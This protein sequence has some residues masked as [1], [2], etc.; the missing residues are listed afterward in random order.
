MLTAIFVMTI[1]I[2]F[3]QLAGSIVGG[4]AA[5]RSDQRMKRDQAEHERRMSATE[6]VFSQT[7]AGLA[8]SPPP[9]APLHVVP[10]PKSKP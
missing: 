6:R 3:L 7:V 4:V 8:S 10:D 1:I 9:P 2:L 5:Y